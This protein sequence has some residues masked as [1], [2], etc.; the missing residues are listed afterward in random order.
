MNMTLRIFSTQL[1]KTAV[2]PKILDC[3]LYGMCVCVS[4]NDLTLLHTGCFEYLDFSF[5]QFGRVGCFVF[6][7]A[8]LN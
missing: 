2:G 5:N 3:V 4:G 8:E 6:F 7:F 1:H